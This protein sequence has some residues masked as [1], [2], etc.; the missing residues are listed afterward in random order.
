MRTLCALLLLVFVAAIVVFATQNRDSVTVNFL[1]RHETFTL[2][3]IVGAV[4][5]LGMVSGWTVVGMLKRTFYR[6]TEWR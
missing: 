1:D 4:Y 5:L 2:S 3:A 6:A